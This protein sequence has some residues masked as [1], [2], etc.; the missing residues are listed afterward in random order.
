MRETQVQP[1][2]FLLL[3]AVRSLTKRA[4]ARPRTLEHKCLS[5]GSRAGAWLPARSTGGSAVSLGA[6]PSLQSCLTLCEPMDH[7]P[8]DSSVHGLLQAEYWSGLPFPTPGDLPNPG[9]QPESLSCPGLAGGFF[10]TSATWEEIPSV[11]FSSVAH[12]CPTLRPQGLQ[13]TRLPCPSP[14]PRVYSKSHA[15][16]W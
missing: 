4:H 1:H 13:H 6:T 9:I 3:P 10:T 14:T 8:T 12:S 11:Q 15:S 2:H 16:S 7:S 5:A